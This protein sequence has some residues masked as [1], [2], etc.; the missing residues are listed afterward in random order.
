LRTLSGLN[1]P[2]LLFI[3]VSPL[4]ALGGSIWWIASGSWNLATIVLAGVMA[5]VSGLAITG[6]YHRLFSHRSYA[7]AGPVRFGLLLFGAASFEESALQ[8]CCD[9]RA[10]HR[11]IDREGDPYNITKGFWHAHFFWMF[12][13]RPNGSDL[14]P[15]DL[16]SDPLIRL[17]HRFYLPVAASMGLL[18][19][20]GIASIWGDPWGGLLIAGFLRIVLNHHLTF[21]I[22]S[23]CHTL[24]NQPYSDRHSARD[25]WL[26]A[27]FTYGEGY[28]NFHHEFPADY[29]N[30]HRHYHWD[31]TKW[32]VDLL[33]R[34]G[35]A[36]NLR[37]S[38]DEHI[39][40]K[41][42]AMQEKLAARRLASQS[43]AA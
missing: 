10:H 42:I 21:A 43:T 13:K 28:H 26:T 3:T 33:A 9:H 2:V 29:R 36:G 27:L 12:E 20:L 17:Q 7:A 23:V 41:K 14:R 40:R 19:P 25:H 16:W 4:V 11:H 22:N 8:W 5:I 30:G 31:P 6:G 32:L 37:R 1:W 35:M 34:L 39:V 18:L 24:G 15:A 38:S